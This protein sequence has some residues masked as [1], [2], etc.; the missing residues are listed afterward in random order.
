M[1]K[2]TYTKKTYVCIAILFALVI[3]ACKSPPEEIPPGITEA[4][5][6]QMAQSAVDDNNYDNA[7]YY[8]GVMLSLFGSNP[9][10]VVIAEFELA[11]LDVK[12]KNYKEAEVALNR[13]LAY[14][15]DPQLSMMLPQSYK[16][17]AE[18]DLEK[19]VGAE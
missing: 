14:Y 18:I 2:S 12:E 13:V 11:H 19:V 3:T 5:L 4:E 6:I 7:R 10:S 9:A 16:K 8:Y 17:L 1:K 15:E